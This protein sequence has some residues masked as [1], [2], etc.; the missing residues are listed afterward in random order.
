MTDKRIPRAEPEFAAKVQRALRRAGRD[1][2]RTARLHGVPI[3][4]WKDGK[5][6]ALK[7]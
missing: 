2:R 4:A 5:I 7:P 6:I 3:Y 1:A